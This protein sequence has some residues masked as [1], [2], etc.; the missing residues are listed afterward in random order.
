MTMAAN[1]SLQAGEHG[2]SG[3][4]AGYAAGRRNRLSRLEWRKPGI[5]HALRP[6]LPLI[7]DVARA[8]GRDG[9]VQ[10]V[11]VPVEGQHGGV[12][13]GIDR[14][15]GAAVVAGI[16]QGLRRPVG[17][18]VWQPDSRGAKAISGARRIIMQEAPL[19][20]GRRQL[21]HG[22]VMPESCRG[23]CCCRSCWMEQHVRCVTSGTHDAGFLAR[24]LPGHAH[25]A[26]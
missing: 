20:S 17:V 7:A 1:A 2:L 19:H 10:A 6:P 24:T 21:D 23:K 22:R 11:G 16:G 14:L 5:M 25:R 12:C 15:H 9:G 26:T 4:R 13:I 3:R 8:I 18:G